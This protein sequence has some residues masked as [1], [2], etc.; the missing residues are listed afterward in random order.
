[1]MVPAAWAREDLPSLQIQPPV[2]LD[3]D[4]FGHLYVMGMPRSGRSQTLRTIAAAVARANSCADVHFY[5]VDAAGGAL[6]ALSA[7]PHTGAVVPRA[8]IER[9]NRLLNRLTAELVRR[10]EL[11][12]TH[13]A[14]TLTELRGVLPPGQ[15]PAH[16]VLLIDGWDTLNAL[17][18]DIEDGRMVAQV[19]TLLREGSAVGVH[20][21]ATSERALMGGRIAALNDNKLLLRMSEPGDFVMHGID[22][23]RI[24]SAMG[25]GRGFRTEGGNELQV[26]VLP[27][28]PSGQEQAE[29]L[30]LIGSEAARRD[31]DVPPSARPFRI[32]TLP[33]Q[34]PFKDAWA[35]ASAAEQRRPLHG[36]VGLGGDDV[37]P[38][39]A[40]FAGV[41]ASY[42]IVGP[43]GSGR[44]T[45]LA[46]LAASLLRGGTGVVAL[47]PR[48]SPLR[49]LEGRRGAAVITS[50]QPTEHDV[51]TA[52]E[53]VGGGPAVL[54]VD[55]ADLL[56]MTPADNLLRDIAASGR[57]R[58]LGIAV[59]GPAE[60]LVSPLSSWIGQ[61]RRSRKGLLLSPQ[62]VGEGDIL[63]LRLP[64]NIIRVNRVP[65]RGYTTDVTGALLTV[66]VPETSP[67][68]D[69]G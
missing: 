38:V 17:I 22:R 59:A 47:T 6:S 11:L 48:E 40:D 66:L 13:S 57:D 54:L 1:R 34:I 32:E 15:R 4:E 39:W 5:A 20:V 36:L 10:Q 25:P 37:A 21:V 61:V 45:A 62:S 51:T 31:Q 16:L 63:G 29:A 67:G 52:L 14:S 7:L 28:G 49:A 33:S 26:A 44:S 24:P 65:G 9:L 35:R 3:L 60:A 43:P 68:Q 56:A 42:V 53:S 46:S 8:D 2:M 50:L 27:G 64:H 23:A 30:R 41:S 69:A 19:A 18:S 55:D 58:S 12:A